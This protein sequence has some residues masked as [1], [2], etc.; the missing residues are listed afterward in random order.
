M[1]ILH[2]ILYISACLLIL[3]ACNKNEDNENGTG[4]KTPQ[5]EQLDIIPVYTINYG[6]SYSNYTSFFTYENGSMVSGYDSYDEVNFT[7]KKSPLEIIKTDETEDYSYQQRYYNIKTNSFGSITSAD[8]SGTERNK[9]GLIIYSLNGTMKAEY[10]SLGQLTKMVTTATEKDEEETYTYSNQFIFQYENGNLVKEIDYYNSKEESSMIFSY[11]NHNLYNNS[12]V[13]LTELCLD[14]P[15]MYYAG[16]WGK[17][18]K[19]IPNSYIY[20][21]DE[22]ENDVYVE[23]DN[24][25]RVSIMDED[26]FTQNFG[27]EPVSFVKNKSV[28]QTNKIHHSRLPKLFRRK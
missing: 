12:G 8:V 22:E 23:Y 17:P 5:P 18:S 19:N 11:D 4:D 13:F 15:F 28:Q 26:G 25:G 27:Y 24:K 7:I 16:L 3:S 20:T 2:S 1:K 10:N 6:E 21:D 9:D 14:S